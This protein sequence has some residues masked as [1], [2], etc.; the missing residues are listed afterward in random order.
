MFRSSILGRW[1]WQQ[2]GAQHVNLLSQG[3]VQFLQPSTIRLQAASRCS[4]KTLPP[5]AA[6]D[7]LFVCPVDFQYFLFQLETKNKVSYGSSIASILP[8]EI[9]QLSGNSSQTP[10][11]VHCFLW[12]VFQSFLWTARI[13]TP[14]HFRSLLAPAFWALALILLAWTSTS[15]HLT[16]SSQLWIDLAGIWKVL[17]CPLKRKG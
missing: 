17:F 6:L 9:W 8:F 2:L 12:S 3:P 10:L 16:C 11:S 7:Q 4:L 5:I 14:W 15:H 13:R 1:P